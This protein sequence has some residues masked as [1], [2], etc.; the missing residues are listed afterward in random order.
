MGSECQSQCTFAAVGINV[1]NERKASMKHEQTSALNHT[2]VSSK[3]LHQCLKWASGGSESLP[4]NALTQFDFWT[5]SESPH[6]IGC[7]TRVYVWFVSLQRRLTQEQNCSS[8]S[9]F[10]LL[11]SDSCRE[12]F[13]VFVAIQSQCSTT[14]TPQPRIAFRCCSIT[15]ALMFWD[16][17]YIRGMFPCVCLCMRVMFRD[18]FI[19]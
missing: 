6:L 16:M 3:S 5:C 10:L 4:V 11:A 12:A 9:C 7:C 2:Q 14:S 8:P 17:F 15:C 19:D 1:G 13:R 18:G